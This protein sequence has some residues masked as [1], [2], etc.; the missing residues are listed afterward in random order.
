MG[1]LAQHEAQTEYETALLQKVQIEAA[2]SAST[3]SNFQTY[4]QTATRG[5]IERGEVS[6]TIAND[7]IAEVTTA[8]EGITHVNVAAMEAGVLGK[9]YIGA[10]EE[11][12]RLAKGMLANI[13]TGIDAQTV[14][15]TA[16]HEFAHGDQVQL[17]GALVINGVE[18]DALHLYEGHAEIRGNEATGKS[19][20]A[21]REGQ[22]E[23]VYK[24]GQNLVLGI[25]KSVSRSKLEQVM[26]QTGDLS[27]LQ[28]KI[29][30]QEVPA[31][32]FALAS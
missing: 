22:P 5:L 13:G 1:R 28:R 15:H 17:K 10:G 24:E 23:K 8:T 3:V 7:R 14:Q 12:A 2:A 11:G 21:Y 32:D 6:A 9:N 31:Q 25:L 20:N 27:V 16:A 30:G 19:V 18:V 4:F 29:D 26:T